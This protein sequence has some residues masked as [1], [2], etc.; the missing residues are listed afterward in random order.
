MALNWTVFDDRNR[1]V[2]LPRETLIGEELNIDIVVRIPD[3]PPQGG[4]AAG[5]IGGTGRT[6]KCVGK[7]WLSNLRVSVSYSCSDKQCR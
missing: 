6:L 1:P 4:A 2:P 7:V 3:S 5:G